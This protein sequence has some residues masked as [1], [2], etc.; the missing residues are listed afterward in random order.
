MPEADIEKPDP[1]HPLLA[2][3]ENVSL[4]EVHAALEADPSCAVSA[5]DDRGRTALS[6]AAAK[7]DAK[8]VKALLD[9]KAADCAPISKWSA[10]QYAAFSGHA[11]VLAALVAKGG[12]SVAN[13]AG[14][15]MTPLLLACNKGHV[16]C[17]KLLLD[18]APESLNALAQGRTPLM[19]AAQSGSP[20]TIE[21]LHSRGAGLDDTSPDGRTALMWAVVSHKPSC[22][23]KLA[24]LG[25]NPEICAP[26]PETAAIVPGQNRDKGQ[27]AEDFANGKHNRDPTLRHIA[28]Y[29][30]QWREQRAATPDAGAPD[31][32]PLP[33][34]AHAEMMKAKAEAEAA[35]KPAEAT[36]EGQN[37]IASGEATASVDENDIFGDDDTAAEEDDKP[38]GHSGMKIVDVTEEA[39][40]PTGEA[41]KPAEED[42]DLDALD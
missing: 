27:S 6:H 31:M 11:D 24:K 33:W 41:A 42:G 26:I 16:D 15:S 19:L 32:D 10:A 4:D 1:V 3:I 7:G 35:A 29:L 20:E 37:A 18:E 8:I 28:I 22:V 5:A 21:L 14:V 25:G 9:A 36:Q 13:P 40:A 30:R 38:S 23:E 39:K 34:V 17:A 12:K 2:A